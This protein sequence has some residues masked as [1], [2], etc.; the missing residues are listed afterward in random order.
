MCFFRV[1]FFKKLFV[2]I[3]V[4]TKRNQ[5]NFE[6]VFG[7]GGEFG[8]SVRTMHKVSVSQIPKPMMFP[9]RKGW[10]FI[11]RPISQYKHPNR[12]YI[13]RTVKAY[14]YQCIMS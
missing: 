10:L 6:L 4:C 9:T 8:Q 12:E 2:L 1:V 7:R 3:A 5:T 13:M 14:K 11:P